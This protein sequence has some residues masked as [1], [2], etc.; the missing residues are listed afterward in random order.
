MLYGA[1]GCGKSLVVELVCK[2]AQDGPSF[3][4]MQSSTRN[5]SVEFHSRFVDA[6][7]WDRQLLMRVDEATHQYSYFS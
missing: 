5:P 7:K 2:L 1:K 6:T 3:S 4:E